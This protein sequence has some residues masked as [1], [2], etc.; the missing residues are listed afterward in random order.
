MFGTL[1]VRIAFSFAILSSI[2]Y[3]AN[4]LNKQNKFQFFSRLFYH[5]S[6]VAIMF[7]SSLMI[8]LIMT[9]HFEYNY[10][11][12]HSSTDL[13]PSLLFST[14]YAGQEG[15]FSLWA[16]FTGILGIFLMQYSQKR[17]Y[18]N[19]LM[20]IYSLIYASL[21]LMI[22]VKNPFELI[23]NVFP[24]ELI[25]TGIPSTENFIWINEAKQI[26]AQ[27]PTEGRGLN[28]LLQNYWMV[29]H[30]P[31]L[32][33]GFT[34]LSVPFAHAVAALLKK[35]FTFWIN[36]AK[37]WV[38]F[39]ALSLGTGIIL[40]GYWAYETLGWG[41]FWGW[42]PV[43]NSSFV[44]WLTCIA[45]IHTMLTQSKS[46]SF[47]KTNFALS[48]I[49]FL[50]V[51]YSTFLTRSGVLGD[52]SVHSFVDPGMLVYWLLVGVILLFAFIGFGLL[53]YRLKSMPIQETKHSVLS[54]DFMLFLGASTLVLLS[55]FVALGTSS[56]IITNIIKGKISAV[57][58]SF[59]NS[60]ALPLSIIIS[61][62]IAFGQ[63][64]WWQSAKFS[65]LIQNIKWPLIISTIITIITF[66]FGL[67]DFL[68]LIYIFAAN[69]SLFVNIVTVFK[70]SKNN[71]THIGGSITHIGLALMFIGFL[72]SSK[73]D[74]KKTVS[75][76]ADKNVSLFG[77]NF[78]YK[79]Y[80]QIEKNRYQINI[81]VTEGNKTFQVNPIMFYNEQDKNLLRNP[82]IVN[83]WTKDL[84]IAPVSIEEPTNSGS[85]LELIS[86]V[87]TSFND[88]KILYK[89]FNF[90]V[91]SGVG[92]E[93]TVPIVVEKNGIK[94][95]IILKMVMQ[96][97]EVN[98]ETTEFEDFQFTIKSVPA[99]G[100]QNKPITINILNNKDNNSVQK[101]TLIA[102]ISI[103]PFINL[104]WLGTFLLFVGFIITI[105][106]RIKESNF[107]Y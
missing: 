41:G 45:L 23:W 83:L 21:L 9:H 19:E 43:E 80:T 22:V 14:F 106:R 66:A 97:G 78:K 82:D 44:P 12:G 6:T 81:D 39:A 47:L 33:L 59:Y 84:Y 100:D 74:D 25:K 92:N 64:L 71:S 3:F 95:N 103:K 34:A 28:P 49:S 5:V 101:E 50:L 63:S 76:V 42:D 65:D 16:F 79:N 58:I 57:D 4:L 70:I 20:S 69:L 54:R 99:G 75:L 73:Y 30:P 94:N 8:Y 15:S 35:D 93:I 46:G 107:N 68:I 102:E 88:L 27:I 77:Y 26:W 104:V 24:N 98:Y 1:L 91:V 61:L 31:I 17:N 11:W 87:P 72:T 29:I 7:S 96:K 55:F 36:V 85:D 38:I 10:I 86:N 51:L 2:F 53:I 90:E 56:P 89:N 105:I 13:S 18:E 67:N 32:F 60:T 62:L 37:P 52:T 48:I 40:G